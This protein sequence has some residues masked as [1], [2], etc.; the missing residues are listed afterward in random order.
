MLDIQRSLPKVVV[1]DAAL[2]KMFGFQVCEIV[3][4]N[5]SLRGIHVVL[6]GAIHDQDR[7]RRPPRDLY[8]ADVYVERH[9]LPDALFPLLEG[10][11]VPLG[12]PPAPAEPAPP[13]PV[14]E[15]EPAP[16]PTPPA[17][18]APVTP[19]PAAFSRRISPRAVRAGRYQ[20]AHPAH[21]SDLRLVVLLTVSQA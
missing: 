17:A 1:L 21:K 20:R 11:G 10:F 15:R 9:E 8:G 6:V 3:K 5:E 4:R 18:P 19:T 12:P 16:S 14:L 13:P 2:P 7:Y